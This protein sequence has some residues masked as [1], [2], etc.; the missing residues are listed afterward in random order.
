MKWYQTI[1][2]SLQKGQQSVSNSTFQIV[3][4]KAATVGSD[5]VVLERK[6]PYTVVYFHSKIEG[7]GHI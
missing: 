1:Y 3:N 2:N 6:V 4:S 5:V 7:A